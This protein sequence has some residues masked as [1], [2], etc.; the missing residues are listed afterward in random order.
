MSATNSTATIDLSQYIGTDKPTYLVDYNGDML[1]IDNAIA[2]DRDN[3]TAAQSKADTADGKA[4]ANASAIE[5]LNEEVNGAT[6]GLA[7]RVGNLEGSVNSINSLIGNGTPTTDDKTL[8]GAINELDGDIG[9]LDTLSTSSKI[10]VGA[11]NEVASDI[12]L[13]YRPFSNDLTADGI[14]T[15]SEILDGLFDV[16]K[17][18]TNSDKLY[19]LQSAFCPNVPITLM[20]RS[21][22]V[23]SGSAINDASFWAINSALTE[24]YYCQIRSSGSVLKKVAL[25]DG[26]VTDLSSAVPTAG[27]NFSCIAVE[28]LR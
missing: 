13:S 21:L 17:T 22:Y 1:K 26:T 20:T 19:S 6:T 12:R 28:C 14:K 9:D 4:D 15:V 10:I 7:T 8:I 18:N 27:A 23:Q 16:F 2:T 3:I 25:S 11:I 5:T 24:I